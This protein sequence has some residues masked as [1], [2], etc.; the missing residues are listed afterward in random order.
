MSYTS[1]LTQLSFISVIK[2]K[3]TLAPEPNLFPAFWLKL[4]LPRCFPIAISLVRLNQ[5]SH[6][7]MCQTDENIFHNAII[8]SFLRLH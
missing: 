8:R 4:M 3:F 7:R 1:F 2:K 6:E 5:V